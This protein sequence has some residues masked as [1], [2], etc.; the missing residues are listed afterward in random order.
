VRALVVVFALLAVVAS[1][2]G[3]ASEEAAPPDTTT[4]TETTPPNDGGR[5][6]PAIDGTTLD[7][8]RLSLA[9]YRGR[10]VL[11]NVWSAW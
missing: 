2:C 10:P 3:Q 8:E 1:G 4:A 9:D 6:A 7:G 5:E 11:V